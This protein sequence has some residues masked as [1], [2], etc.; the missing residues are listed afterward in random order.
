MASQNSEN[1]N[2]KS[3]NTEAVTRR[4]SVKKVL[5]QFLQN[6]QE[7]PC[8]RV[9][10]LIK[11]QASASN[12]IKKE[13]LAQGFSCEFCGNSKNISSYRTPP[14]AASDNITIEEIK[15][16]FPDLFKQ[17]QKLSGKNTRKCSDTM[18]KSIIELISGNKTLTNEKSR[19]YKRFLFCRNRLMKNIGN[20]G[21]K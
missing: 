12:F 6:S 8:P 14:V 20:L 16:I 2:M 5:S 17:Y 11:L 3:T 7:N 1:L 9:S 18:K 13:T 19:D 4:L 10:F 21:S 15:K